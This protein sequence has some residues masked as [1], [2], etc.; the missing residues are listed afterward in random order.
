MTTRHE[1]IER[2]LATATEAMHAKGKVQ[3]MI[4][5]HAANALMAFPLAGMMDSPATEDAAAKLIG[6]KMREHAAHVYV[7]MFEA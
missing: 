6:A 2:A 7:F 5:A 1:A 3:P 4:I